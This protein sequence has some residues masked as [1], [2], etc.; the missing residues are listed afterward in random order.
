[1]LFQLVFFYD[2]TIFLC[3]GSG[4]GQNEAIQKIVRQLIVLVKEA[5]LPIVV[6][7]V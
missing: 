1:M 5:E 7:G 4:L 2:M 6:D 3:V